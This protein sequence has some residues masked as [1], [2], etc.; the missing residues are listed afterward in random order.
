MSS[1]A[2]DRRLIFPR[3]SESYCKQSKPYNMRKEIWSLLN[4]NESLTAKPICRKLGISYK[5][6]NNYVAKEKSLWKLWKYYHK[7]GVGSKCSKVRRCFW[8]LVLEP[9]VQN[10]CRERLGGVLVGVERARWVLS[11]NRNRHL[12]WRDGLGRMQWFENGRV[13]LYVLKPANKGKA[14][15]LFCNGFTK[16]GLVSD[17]GVLDKVLD[18]MRL[19]GGK[20][21]YDAGQRL[22]YLVIRDFKETNGVTIVLGDRSHPEGVHVIFEYQEQVLKADRLICGFLNRFNDL[23]R[24]NDPNKP[25]GAIKPLNGDD[26]AR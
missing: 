7:D 2:K 12:I 26:Y 13:V 5:Q 1:R 21:D 22:P 17:V 6:Y 14:K 11:R 20:A 9:V 18:G 25:V 19:R 16:T 24:A 10:V 4:E 3:M 15:Q 8:D 23:A